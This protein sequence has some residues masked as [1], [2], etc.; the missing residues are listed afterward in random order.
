MAA[1]ERNMKITLVNGKEIV[2]NIKNI[3]GEFKKASNEIKTM[4]RGSEE[5]NAKAKEIKQL[6]GI[7]DE[8][9]KSI[10]SASS[11]WSSFKSM[12]GGVVGA[13]GMG[14]GLAGAL[15]IAKGV[16]NSTEAGADKFRETMSGLKE[17]LGVMSRAL[18]TMDFSNLIKG[19]RDAYNEGKRY[20]QD[21]DLVEDLKRANEIQNKQSTNSN[22]IT[23]SNRIPKF[24]RSL[25][26]SRH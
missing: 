14:A 19:M 20:E 16:I 26:K 13:L 25:E 17:V 10:G 4:T 22:T 5:Y 24:Q 2:N 6:K 21:L 1:T 23:R 3:G 12:L 7:L 8:H 11:A 18:S 9:R 15:T